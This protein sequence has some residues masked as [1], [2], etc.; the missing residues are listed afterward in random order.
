MLKFR[1]RVPVLMLLAAAVAAP[2]R[3]DDRKPADLK[4]GDKAPAFQATDD[5][6]DAWKSADHVGKKVLVVYFFP[7]D[8]TGG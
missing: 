5:Q 7:A 3:A 1:W 2:A 8:F 6:G 4:V